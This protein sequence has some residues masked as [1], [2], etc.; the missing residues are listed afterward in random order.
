MKTLNNLIIILLSCFFIV[1]TSCDKDFEK[2]NTDPNAAN[3]DEFNPGYLFTT[4]QMETGLSGEHTYNN[5]Y[6]FGAFVQHWASLSNV[7]IFNWHGDKYVLHEG[8]NNILWVVTY[9]IEKLLQEV[10]QLS[11]DNPD[12]HNLYNMALIW[13]AFVFHRATD[14]YGDIPFSE[15]GQAFHKG[16]Y[17]PKYDSQE[18]IYYQ[19]LAQLN[20]AVDALDPNQNNFGK[21]D[22]VYNGDIEKWKKMGNSLMLRLAMRL[23]KVQPDK[24]EEWVKKAFSKSLL[25]SNDDNLAIKA[26]DPNATVSQLTNQASFMFSRS[27]TGQISATFFNY[28][29]ERN[30]PR[31][32]YMVA[33]YTDP[34]DASTKNDDPSIQKGLPNGLDRFSLVDDPSYDP[35]HPAQENQYS[36]L[37]RDVYGKLDG[38]RMLL[39][40]AEVQFMLSEAAL[41][42]WISG[43]VKAY[44]EN[45][46]KADMK[47]VAN[48]EKSAVISDSEINE[49]LTDNPFVGTGD[50]NAALEQINNQYWI[51]TFLNGY[52]AYAN[53][54]RSGY[55]KLIPVNYLDNET[56]G[57]MPGRLIYPKNEAVLNEANYKEAVARQG[58][59]DFITHVWWDK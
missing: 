59:D 31:L 7:G 54:R 53:F 22:I 10:I 34:Y 8:N 39:T 43:D 32:K 57:K 5:L 46:V 6:Y 37:N 29:K 4:A 14:A 9:N 51:A 15:A 56:G 35:D 18:S 24:S 13:Q 48:Y 12:Y 44:Y 30:D 33:V 47:N 3:A 11:S 52:E 28:L 23:I 27:A 55:P 45:G 26:L 49:Y 40:Y 16:N 50:Q 2:I 58:K 38:I 20:D 19:M 17:K 21:F 1:F 25:Q 36:T 42:G 41:R